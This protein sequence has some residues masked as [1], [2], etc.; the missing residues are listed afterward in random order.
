MFLCFAVSFFVVFI[1]DFLTE[2]KRNSN[3]LY[4]FSFSTS[5]K[6]CSTCT[7]QEINAEKFYPKTS[8][9]IKY[10]DVNFRGFEV[11]SS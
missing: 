10:S 8:N 9:L 2:A 1:F 7:P 6:S 11:G 5:S 4:R 3:S